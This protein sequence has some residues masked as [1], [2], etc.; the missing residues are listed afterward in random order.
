MKRSAKQNNQPNPIIST[1]WNHA[2]G[3]NEEE[4][5][6]MSRPILYR[7]EILIYDFEEVG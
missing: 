5:Q 4:L 3:I 2:T 6:A 1:S 7:K